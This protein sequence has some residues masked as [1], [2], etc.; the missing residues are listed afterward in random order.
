MEFVRY[1]FETDERFDELRQDIQGFNNLDT[2]WE[3]RAKPIIARIAT[4]L[5]I[6][7]VIELTEYVKS[8]IEKR[9]VTARKN[10]AT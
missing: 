2:L 9:I 5:T 8:V 10:S 4:G 1:I 3:L 6:H 7:E